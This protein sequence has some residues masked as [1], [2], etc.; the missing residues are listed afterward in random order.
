MTVLEDARALHDDLVRMRHD[1]HARPELGLELPYTQ[2]RVLAGLD[3]LPLEVTT[4]QALSS[5]TAVLRGARP[6]P[7]VLLRGDMDALPVTERSGVGYA[8]TVPG[9]MHACGHDLHTTMLAGAAHLLSARR[10]T[11]AGDVVFM[12]QPGEEGPGGAGLMIEEGVLDASGQRAS[13][14]YALHVASAMLPQGV[15]SGRP[16]TALA[17]ADSVTVTVRGQGGHGSMP[18]LA[19]DPVPVA[20]EMVLALQAMVTRR[21]DIFDPVVVTVGSFHAGTVDN[22]IPGEA[23]FHATLRSFSREAHGRIKDEVVAVV[24]GV[25]AA[26][27]LEAECDFGRMSYPVTVN[28]AD[29]AAHVAATVREVLGEERF[30]DAPK[31]GAGAE[32]FSLVLEDVP[33]AMVMLGA[34]PADRDLA[35]APANH[36]PEAAFAD[37]V[38]SDGA[39]IYAELALRRLTA[40]EAEQVA[41]E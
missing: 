2:E 21:F 36:A 34:C 38:L 10:D 3:G 24:R 33:G 17:A 12:F 1:L 9:R 14:A 35:K 5:V 11:L 20:C 40:A 39:A 15:F 28:D 18:Y 19:K 30:R 26:H 37:D 23:V 8:S 32:D 29:E 27:G 25:A 31:P 41:T 13:A 22:V 16:G 4:G 7:T 6:G